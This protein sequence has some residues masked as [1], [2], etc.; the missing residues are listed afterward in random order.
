MALTKPEFLKKWTSAAAGAVMGATALFS[1][2]M[3]QDAQQVAHT[4][5]VCTRD[6]SSE[7]ANVRAGQHS[8]CSRDVAIIV[9]GRTD[10][11]TGEE[12]GQRIVQEFAKRGVPAKFFTEPM[13]GNEHRFA[14]SYWLKGLSYGTY[15]EDW[16]NGFKQVQAEYPRVWAATQPTNERG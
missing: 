9:T 1:P 3:G 14:V 8:E 13:L 12:I 15:G 6:F 5:D 2:A 4:Q 7:S 16:A 11:Y 10:E